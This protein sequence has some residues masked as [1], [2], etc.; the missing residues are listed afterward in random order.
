MIEG[1]KYH[2][3]LEELFTLQNIAE[4]TV[5]RYKVFTF[6]LDS[7][8]PR[9]LN[10]PGRLFFFGFTHLCEFVNVALS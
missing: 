4:L 7:K 10:K 5:I 8:Y 2:D 3:S 6:D 1:G 9:N